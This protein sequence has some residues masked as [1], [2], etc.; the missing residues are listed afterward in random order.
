MH[1]M[2]VSYRKIDRNQVYREIV[3]MIE[4]SPNGEVEISSSEL[5]DKF[6]VQATTMDYH[7]NRL[8]EEG[9]ITISPRRGRY[10]RK[11]YR[12]P[13]NV[14]EKPEKPKVELHAPFTP[15]SAEKFKKFL[16]EHVKKS[17][18]KKQEPEK[19]EEDVQEKLELDEK[20]K[21]VPSIQETAVNAGLSQVKTKPAPI[22]TKE[23]TLDERIERFLQQANQVHDAHELLKHE[24]KEI[25]SVMNETIHQTIVYLK[26]LSEQLSTVQNK[27][28]IL[29]LIEDRNR[30]QQKIERLEK[31]LDETRAQVDQ[32]IKQYKIDPNRVRFMHQLIID[33]VDDY[34]NR[35]NHALA[36]GRAEFREKISKEVSDLVKYVLHLE[37]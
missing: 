16:E 37:E 2:V 15:E 4:Q 32:T 29:H 13:E 12:L 7:L 17:K 33:T 3:K 24:D 20:P 36:L 34:V 11:V 25:L 10:R 5:A 18:I 14:K 31:E 30:M 27:E 26:D 19:Q 23:L 22:Q 6:G 28:L 35:P 9:Y 8:V 1:M 21:E